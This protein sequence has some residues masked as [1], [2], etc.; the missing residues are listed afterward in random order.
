MEAR[1]TI[2]GASVSRAFGTTAVV[3]MAMGLA[4]AG[5]YVAGSATQ[6][7]AAG[8]GVIAVHPAPG[9]VLRQDNPAQAP[10][11]LPGYLQQE[12]APKQVAPVIVDDPNY[13]NQYLASP[14]PEQG[15]PLAPG[16]QP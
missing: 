10:A 7:S 2:R 8:N 1:A 4:A 5:G 11:E 14:S 6:H 13:I 16:F 3:L 9:T 12:I 15:R